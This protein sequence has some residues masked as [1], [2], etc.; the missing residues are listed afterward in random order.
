MAS[1]FGREPHAT[2]WIMKSHSST[3]DGKHPYAKWNF[4][5][6]PECQAVYEYIEAQDN[7]KTLP[8]MT[9]DEWEAFIKK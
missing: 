5:G 3:N 7:K 2:L 8:L 9:K 6:T 1:Y 4:T